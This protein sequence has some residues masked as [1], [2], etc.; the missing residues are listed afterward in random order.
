V[1]VEEVAKPAQEECDNARPVGVYLIKIGA[2][3][4]LFRI[5]GTSPNGIKSHFRASSGCQLIPRPAH[6]QRST[7]N[8]SLRDR[9][10]RGTIGLHSLKSVSRQKQKE[11]NDL[12]RGATN[13]KI[14]TV[15]R[16]ALI[17]ALQK[18][19]T[20]DYELVLA[21]ALPVADHCGAAV[22]FCCSACF[23]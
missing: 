8:Q 13:A 18:R 20:A 11:F 12:L 15:H 1:L 10:A 6:P 19:W 3:Y 22:C 7:L 4:R 14:S 21:N 16:V 9:S 5:A 23:C 17:W 2:S